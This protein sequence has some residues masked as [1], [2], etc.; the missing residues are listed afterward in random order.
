MKKLILPIVFFLSGVFLTLYFTG[1]QKSKGLNSE[2]TSIPTIIEQ[3]KYNE[4]FRD[5]KVLLV[6]SNKG[7]KAESLEIE[8]IIKIFED[9]SL[10]TE[11]I[12]FSMIRDIS[13]KYDGILV[14]MEESE[15]GE[16]ENDL[17]DLPLYLLPDGVIGLINGAIDVFAEKGILRNKRVAGTFLSERVDK[18]EKSG[19]IPVPLGLCDDKG[20]ITLADKF[21]IIGFSYLFMKHLRGEEKN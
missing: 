12:D 17:F 2:N 7:R 21:Q 9:N 15:I 16:L 10:E 8:K 14:A 11:I 13:R 3:K 20:I 18:L 4:F 1:N 5:K 19:A 6:C